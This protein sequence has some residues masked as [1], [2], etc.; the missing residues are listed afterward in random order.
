MGLLLTL[1]KNNIL[2]TV[3]LKTKLTIF[4]YYFMNNYSQKSKK[5]KKKQAKTFVALNDSMF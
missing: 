4:F 3:T 2:F 5:K 1:N